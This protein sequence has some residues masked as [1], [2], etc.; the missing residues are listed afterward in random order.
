MTRGGLFALQGTSWAGLAAGA[1][2]WAVDTQLNYALVPWACA[3]GRNIVPAIAGVLAVVS[4]LGAL[5]SLL[6]W[7]R[8]HDPEC[9]FP[10]RTAIP[11]ICCPGSAPPRACCSRS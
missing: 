10:S 4:L 2:A 1:T 11:G 3:H 7:R 6:A 9:M 8:H 5:S